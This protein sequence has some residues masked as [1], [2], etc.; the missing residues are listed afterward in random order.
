M[1][2]TKR[3]GRRKLQVV[4]RLISSCEYQKSGRKWLDFLG[5]ISTTARKR[6]VAADLM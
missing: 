2:I 6:F 4:V 5:V 1:K 3:T